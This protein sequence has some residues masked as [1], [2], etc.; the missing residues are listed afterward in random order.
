MRAQ[1]LLVIGALAAITSTARAQGD[2]ASLTLTV[3]QTGHPLPGAEVRSDSVRARTDARGVAR[4]RLA[5]GPR[6]LVVASIGYRPDTI[7]VVLQPLR[8]TAI[9]VEL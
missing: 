4:L 8:D 9:A 5:A 3:R 6:Q 2:S 1:G 7:Q